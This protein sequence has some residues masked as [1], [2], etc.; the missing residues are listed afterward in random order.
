MVHRV[1]ISLGFAAL[2][3]F[4]GWYDCQFCLWFLLCLAVHELGHGVVMWM[5]RI[6]IYGLTLNLTGAMIHSSPCTYKH[7]LLCAI[8]GPA[9]S[10]LLMWVLFRVE[11]RVALLSGA[12]GV[13]NLLPLYPL[14]GGRML[15]AALL[16]KMEEDRVMM[17]L[18]RVTF[19]ICCLLMTIACW[20]AA[21]LQ[22]GLW[23][24]FAVLV[25]LCRVGSAGWNEQ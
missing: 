5:C 9:A 4:L 19:A 23:P 14:D 25:V 7:E 6:P 22:M 12:L 18:S 24:V 3:C 10:F 16:L 11:S 15:R 8:A 13:M 2:I 20:V 17:I 21:E 1:K